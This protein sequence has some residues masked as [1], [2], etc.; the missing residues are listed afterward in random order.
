MLNM[1]IETFSKDDITIFWVF[2]VSRHPMH[3]TY[4]EATFARTNKTHQI[5]ILGSVF[6]FSFHLLFIFVSTHMFTWVIVF[7]SCEVGSRDVIRQELQAYLWNTDYK[8][9]PNNANIQV[10]KLNARKLDGVGPVD[11]RPSTDQLHHF[12][13]K[14]IKKIKNVT[15]DP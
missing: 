12:V 1:Y 10:P 5:S 2:T 6:I 7:K 15:P 11:N 8:F 4:I 3:F 13:Q 9:S 14:K